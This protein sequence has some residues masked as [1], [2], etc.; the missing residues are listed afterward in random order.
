MFYENLVRCAERRMMHSADPLHGVDHVRRVVQSAEALAASFSFS[1]EERA[2]LRL[3]AW[4]HDV[5]RMMVH[6]PSLVIM[7]FIDDFLSGCLLFREA[8]RSAVHRDPVVR[9]AVRIL[10]CKSIGVGVLISRLILTARERLLLDIVKDAD[11]LDILCPDRASCMFQLVEGS[12]VYRL[13]YQCVIWWFLF[14][15]HLE[16]RTEG[17]Q[18]HAVSALEQMLVFMTGR[19]MLLWHQSHFG[20]SWVKKNRLRAD[21]LLCRTREN[22]LAQRDACV[23]YR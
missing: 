22:V 1:F 8:F 20:F 7:P 12:R 19:E 11:A 3:S 14:S 5:S 18:K 9:L 21:L 10:V 17:A 4:W 16:M 23:I 2:A 15:S 13:G 6:K